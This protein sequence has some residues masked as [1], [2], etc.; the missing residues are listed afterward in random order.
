MKKEISTLVTNLYLNTKSNS[1]KEINDAMVAKAI[2]IADTIEPDTAEEYFLVAASL[3][4]LNTAIKD[5]RWKKKLNY[6]YIKPKAAELM[7]RIIKFEPQHVQTYYADSVGYVEVCGVQF[8]FH[9][10]PLDG[11]LRSFVNSSKN[12]AK[13]WKGIRLHSIAVEVFEIAMDI[14]GIFNSA[15]A[16]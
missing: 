12:Q 7:K 15:S 11:F 2:A 5:K 10:V 3:N 14:D 6:G 8:S 13:E 1:S 16:A 9:Y 4:L